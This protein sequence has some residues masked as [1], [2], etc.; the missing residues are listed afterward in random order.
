MLFYRIVPSREGPRPQVCEQNGWKPSTSPQPQRWSAAS[1]GLVGFRVDWLSGF[2]AKFDENCRPVDIAA[3][4]VHRM[5]DAAPICNMATSQVRA[6]SVLRE[7]LATNCACHPSTSSPRWAVIGYLSVSALAPSK[8][9]H[10]PNPSD[11]PRTGAARNRERASFRA[12]RPFA[13]LRS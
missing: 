8:H 12:R 6:V 4:P 13:V 11:E 3:I 9:G 7:R 5:L 10:V 1:G 2:H